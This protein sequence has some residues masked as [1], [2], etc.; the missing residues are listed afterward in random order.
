MEENELQS[1]HLR[2]YLEVIKRRKKIVLISFGT[3]VLT[4]IIVSLIMFPT[5]ESTTTIMIEDEKGMGIPFTPFSEFT[6]TDEKLNTQVMI[7]KSRTVAEKV[8]NKLGLQLQVK[9]EIRMG[10]IIL[11]SLV[12]KEKEKNLP[13]PAT[14]TR[15]KLLKIAEGVSGRKYTGIFKNK[16][17]FILYDEQEQEIGRGE[18]GQAFSTPDFSLQLEGEGKIGKKFSF[19]LISL[20]AAAK[21][22]QDNVEISPVRNSSLINIKVK[23]ND[24]WQTKEIADTIVAVY[25]EIM[26]SKRT[27]EASQVITFLEEQTKEVEKDLQRAEENLRKFKEKEKMVV[28]EAEIKSAL[29]RVAAFEKEY[30]AV[31]NYRKQAEIVL[32]AMKGAELFPEKEA[33]FSLGAGLNNNL[34]IEMGK[35]LA[36]LTGQRSALRAMLKE[37]HPRVEQIDREIKNIK[38]SIIAELTG[39]ISSLKVSEKE[40]LNSMKKYEAKIQTLPSAEKE[41]FGLERVVKVGQALNSFLLQK[42]AELGVTK[43]S[44]LGNF[45]V[46]DPANFPVTPA[47]PNIFLNA[48]LALATGIILS[49]GIAFFCEYL[50][51]S[52]KTPEQLTQI[53][54]LPYLGAVYHFISGKKEQELKMLSEPHSS[55]A[56]AFRTIRT[57][58]L[59]TFM[60]EEKKIILITSSGPMEGKTFI[61]AN[62]AVALAQLNKKVLVVEADLRKPSLRRLFAN[63]RTPGLSN[64][65]LKEKIDAEHLPVKKTIIENL[66]LIP[67]GDTPPNPADLLG[68]ERMDGFLSL[69]REKYDFVLLDTPPASSISDAL[70]LAQKAD[71]IIFVVRSGNV[72][73]NIL[74]DVLEKFSRMEAKLLGIILNDIALQESRYYKYHYYYYEEEGKIEKRKKKIKQ[75]PPPVL[76]PQI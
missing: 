31:E 72:E 60:G 61:T 48:L 20:P 3:I 51:T 69:V 29:E 64:L 71:G 49:L 74:R 27:R 39:L 23:G 59:F 63:D 33:L 73:K 24:P 9:P 17:S 32:T 25:K 1:I 14:V 46:V 53:T 22:L 57:N 7:L 38:Q 36:E 16:H 28:L 65:L 21:A 75:G 40:L 12:A 11:N 26:I 76:P 37:K 54:N 56:E 50:D 68:S 4:T 62:L 58:L 45:W 2:D 19:T 43:A 44:E 35:K 70:V 41:L 34:L 67:S 52:V 10:H 6:R 30:K 42:R 5:Y 55:I 66:D 47:K 18:V 8:V 15:I 13:N